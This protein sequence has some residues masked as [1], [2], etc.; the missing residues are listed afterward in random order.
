MDFKIGDLIVVRKG[1]SLLEF[2]NQDMTKFTNGSGSFVSNPFV[3]GVNWLPEEKGVGI[4][5]KFREKAFTI[6]DRFTW[7]RPT[8]QLSG[9]SGVT[10]KS[11]GTGSWSWDEPEAEQKE[12]PNLDTEALIYW[13]GLKRSSWVDYIHLIHIRDRN[14]K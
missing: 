4:I 13:S 8:I 6:G 10:Y 1:L 14:K 5:L 9:S 11:M 2:E 12:G 3:F 7:T